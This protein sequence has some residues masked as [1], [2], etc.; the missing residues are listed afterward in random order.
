[1]KKSKACSGMVAKRNSTGSNVSEQV[2]PIMHSLPICHTQITSVLS[3]VL[4]Y[5]IYAE[6]DKPIS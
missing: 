5:R 1:M 3:K 6:H 2:Q 4:G